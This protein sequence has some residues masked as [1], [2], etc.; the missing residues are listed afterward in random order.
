[1]IRNF[2]RTASVL[3]VVTAGSLALVACGETDNGANGS[4]E[5][6]TEGL[7]GTTGQLVGEGASSQQNAMDY[8]NIQYQEAVDG[9]SLAYNAT[10]SGS[11][12]TNFVAGQ[13]AFGGSD[14][15]LTDEQVDQ[16]FDR[17]DGNEAWHLP[18]VIGPIAI[19]YNLEGVEGLNLST[20]TLVQIF[21]GEITTWDDEAIAAENEG[22]ELPDTDISVIYRSDESGT[23]DNFQQ[24]LAANSDEWTTEGQQFPAEV[25]AGANGSNGVATETSNVEGAITYVEAGFAQQQ[26]LGVANIDFG[27]GPAELNA[28]NVGVALDELEFL[29]EGHNMVLDTEA[30]Y[31]IDEAGAYP[32]VLAAYEIVCSAGYDE[33]TSNMVKDFLTVALDSQDESLEELGYI[34]VTGEHHERLVE[35]VEAIQ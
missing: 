13:V 2:K 17:C 11:G 20:D 6:S 3:G 8:F 7:S 30:M 26:G 14:S 24:F 23:T 5:V 18:L 1:M 22:V 4:A 32:L 21:L 15:P 19:A 25:G 33:D 34:P 29:G 9:A 10:G 31:A 28:E 16:A 35:A 27:N 12:R